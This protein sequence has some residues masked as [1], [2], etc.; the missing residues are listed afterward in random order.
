[1]KSQSPLP[2]R[3]L[4]AA[5]AAATLAIASCGTADDE[6]VAGPGDLGHIHDLV[7]GDDGRLLVASHTGLYRVDDLDRAVLIGTEQHDLMAMASDDAGLLASGHPDL[8]V[9]KYEVQDRPPF[10]GLARSTDSGE[11]W[12]VVDLLGDADFHAL[13]PT[14]RGLFAAEAGGRIWRLDD[15]GGWTQLGEVLARDLAVDP[16]DPERQLAADYDGTTWVS[17]DG[18]ANWNAVSETPALIEIEWIGAEMLLGVTEAGVV[19]RA[20]GPEGPWTE[21]AVASDAVELA[22]ETFHVDR[23]GEWW[24][25]VHGGAIF[26]SADTGATWDQAYAPPAAP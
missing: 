9:E 15:S 6:I 22:V 17:G 21:T 19:W 11:T 23:L 1:M 5:A 7:L 16:S 3:A 8:R 14:S 20:E 2:K 10:L 26:R 18:A 25:T 24:I 4:L 13:V 12:K